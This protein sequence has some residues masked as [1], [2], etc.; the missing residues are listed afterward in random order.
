MSHADISPSERRSS[1]V[2]WTAQGTWCTAAPSFRFDC[3]C[4]VDSGVYFLNGCPSTSGRSSSLVSRCGRLRQPQQYTIVLCVHAT[5]DHTDV[6][7]MGNEVS[8]DTAMWTS[9]CLG[10]SRVWWSCWVW[11]R[12]SA[13]GTIV[14]RLQLSFSVWAVRKSR[15]P[16]WSRITQICAS[17]PLL[18]HVEATVMMD[19]GAM[20]DICAVIWASGPPC[21]PS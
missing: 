2:P 8:Y 14:C 19:N 6:V 9:E 21:P 1:T 16:S 4:F 13:S 7:E 3:T 11:S 5:C 20:C 17:N 12:A 15:Q 10:V 18:D